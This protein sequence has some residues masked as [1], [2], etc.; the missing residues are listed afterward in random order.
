M[1]NPTSDCGCGERRQTSSRSD[2]VTDAHDRGNKPS[3]RAASGRSEARVGETVAVDGF[4]ALN[5]VDGLFL[6]AEHL[7][8]MQDYARS[9]TVALATTSGPGVVHGLGVTLDA[10]TPSIAVSPGLAIS[11]DGQ[12]LQLQSCMRIPLEGNLTNLTSSDGFWR[13]ELYPASK[14][15]GSAPVYGSLCNDGCAD[16]TGAAIQ[17]WRDEGVEIRFERD[18]IDGLG[19]QQPGRRRNWLASAY[20][21]RE[22]S[23]GGPWL[24]PTTN[25]QRVASL[26]SRDWDDGTPLLPVET[27]VPLALL[28]QLRGKGGFVLDMWAARRLVDG[29]QGSNTWRNRLAMRPWSIFLAQI[30]QFEDELADLVMTGGRKAEEHAGQEAAT[31]STQETQRAAVT[32]FFADLHPRNPIR[33]SP[34]FKAA[35]AE[36]SRAPLSSLSGVTERSEIGDRLQDVEDST[37][38]PLVELPPAGYLSTTA[39]GTDL[40]AQISKWFGV[41][42][43]LR[44]LRADQVA[45]IMLAA[46][47]HDRIPLNPAGRPAPVIEILVPD[48]RTDKAELQTD[49]YGWVAFVR[50][51]QAEDPE[52]APDR[53]LR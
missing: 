26:E 45:D 35:V 50:G 18:S 44:S 11:P 36:I 33:R 48:K 13:V 8:T 6:S 52:Q 19:G 14:S 46:Q 28:Q 21:E 20:F 7:N 23:R 9:L 37:A 38:L 47:H 43:E 30:L 27:G 10:D 4:R 12:P 17:P 16:G 39:R 51:A 49:S 15:S 41:P 42:V 3:K 40:Q 5:A 25:G 2:T 29:P 31:S 53:K 1:N 32:A 24:T 22:R 34:L